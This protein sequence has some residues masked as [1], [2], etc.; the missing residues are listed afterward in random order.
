MSVE[1]TVSKIATKTQ[2]VLTDL[3]EVEPVL[4]RAMRALAL[5][6]GL[7][8]LEVA[9]MAVEYADKHYYGASMSALEFFVIRGDSIA[10]AGVKLGVHI[11]PGMPNNSAL[12]TS[13]ASSDSPTTAV[14]GDN[15]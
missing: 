9:A 13:K 6:P 8:T 7:Q 4:A 12:T 15:K 5:W 11:M 1:E 10:T 14:T 2:E 3:H